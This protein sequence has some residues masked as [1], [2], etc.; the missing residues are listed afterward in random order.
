MLGFENIFS[1]YI[2]RKIIP[3]VGKKNKKQHTKTTTNFVK[4]IQTERVREAGILTAQY[5]VSQLVYERLG[6]S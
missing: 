4:K 3:F 1:F 6:L 2:E 5:Q